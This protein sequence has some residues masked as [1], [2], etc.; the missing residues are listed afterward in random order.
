LGKLIDYVPIAV[1]GQVVHLVLPNLAYPHVILVQVLLENVHCCVWLARKAKHSSIG[2]VSHVN[3][4][5]IRRLAATDWLRSLERMHVVLEN[6]HYS[7][8][9]EKGHP[10]E[11]SVKEPLRIFVKSL[12]GTVNWHMIVDKLDLLL[13]GL[14][15][16][17]DKLFLYS[18]ETMKISAIQN[19]IANL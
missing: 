10:V 3:R 8:L 12:A 15:G 2:P 5:L 18:I 11:E 6:R 4:T 16:L 17:L 13:I 14:E 7:V 19:H 9:V 1:H